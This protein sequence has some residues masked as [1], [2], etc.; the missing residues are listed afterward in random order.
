MQGLTTFE[1]TVFFVAA[2]LVA[3]ASVTV[4]AMILTEFGL[5][6]KD[7][8]DNALTALGAAG[9]IWAVIVALRLADR[10]ARETAAR[11][12]DD[13]LILAA[14]A[15]D[16]LEPAVKRVR[17]ALAKN[18]FEPRDYQNEETQRQSKIDALRAALVS[19]AWRYGFETISK[20]SPLPG[21]CAM[22]IYKG[23]S[24]VKAIRQDID[25]HRAPPLWKHT[26]PTERDRLIAL[27]FSQAQQ[28]AD[29]V[30]SVIARM[31]RIAEEAGCSLSDEE[32][33]GSPD[34]NLD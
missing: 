18:A 32:L 27:W 20:L 31:R 14:G 10:Q 11:D 21:K 28:A 22:R 7:G 17:T 16:L 25:H 15:V 6:F 9:T 4:A 1:R 30:E 2:G 13:A 24:M 8:L 3:G 33:Y 23:R 19:D 26:P 34:G 12:F 5:E 29:L